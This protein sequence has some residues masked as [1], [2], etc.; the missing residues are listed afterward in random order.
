MRTYKEQACCKSQ[1]RP[2]RYVDAGG[3]QEQTLDDLNAPNNPQHRKVDKMDVFSRRSLLN[4]IVRLQDR[5]EGGKVCWRHANGRTFE[6][7]PD[8]QEP[9]KVRV[10]ENEPRLCYISPDIGCGKNAPQSLLEIWEVD[11]NGYE[12]AFRS[13]SPGSAPSIRDIPWYIYPE[14]RLR[15]IPLSVEDAI[16]AVSDSID[17]NRL[18]HPIISPLT[19]NYD[20]MQ[21]ESE[22]VNDELLRIHNR[23]RDYLASRKV[24]LASMEENI[25]SFFQGLRSM[26]GPVGKYSRDKILSFFNFPSIENWNN[27]ADLAISWDEHH[28]SAWKIWIS[29]D[30]TAPR[31]LNEENEERVWPKIPDKEMFLRILEA[32]RSAPH[33]PVFDKLSVFEK[34]SANEILKRKLIQENAMRRSLGMNDLTDA[35]INEAFRRSGEGRSGGRR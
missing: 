19:L 15:I 7:T 32:A 5:I 25:P 10:I 27:V 6:I 30:P 4:A 34:L 12:K 33:Y 8:D 3:D 18:Y 29:L 14:I 11:P 17:L 13:R 22:K 1:E 23:Q 24:Y 28:Y 26:F 2:C 31:S 20:E 16:Q 35:E 21:V 9:D